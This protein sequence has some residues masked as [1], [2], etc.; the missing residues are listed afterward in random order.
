[1]ATGTIIHPDDNYVRPKQIIGN[2]MSTSDSFYVPNNYRGLVF[3]FDSAVKRLGA[4][5]VTSSSVGGVY[6]LEIIRG[7][8]ITASSSG[9]NNFTITK[10]ASTITYLNISMNESS[11]LSLNT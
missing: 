7:T 5:F 10:P 4:F 3:L 11:G 2:S 6:I 8:D 9:N 1:M